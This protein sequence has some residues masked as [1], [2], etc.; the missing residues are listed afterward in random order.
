M[1]GKIA[2]HSLSVSSDKAQRIGSWWPHVTILQRLDLNTKVQPTFLQSEEEKDLQP[3]DIILTTIC[4]GI[5]YLL[6]TW[7]IFRLWRYDIIL[8]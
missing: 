1:D 4:Y 5:V 3:N 8:I 6:Q 7:L 2:L